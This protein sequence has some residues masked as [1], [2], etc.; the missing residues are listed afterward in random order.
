MFP[1]RYFT[2]RYWTER[3]WSKGSQ[4]PPSSQDLIAITKSKSNTFVIPN[5]NPTPDCFI[6]FIG[7]II[8][9]DEA[10]GFVGT[11][12]DTTA[13]VGSIDATDAGFNGTITDING[14]RGDICH[15]VCD[16]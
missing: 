13:F 12:T 5:F 1:K 16:C 3:Y 7:T 15:D 10:L 8:D 2:L 9:A 11:I 4:P 14:F 6:G